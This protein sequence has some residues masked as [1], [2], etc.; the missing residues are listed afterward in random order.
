MSDD[1]SIEPRWRTLMNDIA[2]GL[3]DEF[4][5]HLQGPAKE[6]G[7]VLLVFPFG[8]PDGQRVNYISNGD[9]RDIISALKEITARFEGQP[10]Q[11]PG[12]A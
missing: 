12:R 11:K 6:T 7:F 3:D 1:G 2:R 10:E 9:R 5:G 8:G 4:N